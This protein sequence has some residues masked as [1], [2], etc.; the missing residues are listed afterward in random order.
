[1]HRITKLEGEAIGSAKPEDA[2][3]VIAAGLI[4]YTVY[5]S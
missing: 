2:I 4:K 1:M 3:N 5:I